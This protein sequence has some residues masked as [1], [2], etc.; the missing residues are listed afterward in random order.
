MLATIT[1]GSRPNIR[2]R[3]QALVQRFVTR[4]DVVGR[5]SETPEPPQSLSR[6]PVRHMYDPLCVSQVGA[7]S[8]RW[9]DEE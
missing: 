1:P 8:V 9:S 6:D 5:D 7:S 2:Q 4:M 3:Q